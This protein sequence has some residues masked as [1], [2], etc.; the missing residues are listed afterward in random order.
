MNPERLVSAGCVVY[1]KKDSSIEIV[2][3]ARRDKT[4]WCLPKGK[5][6]EGEPP[7]ATAEREVK[8]ET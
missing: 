2:L 6:E 3:I 1:R 4:I 5:I 8:E 7:E